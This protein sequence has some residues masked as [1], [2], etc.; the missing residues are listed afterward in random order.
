[1]TPAEKKAFDAGR[2]DLAAA[3]L[4][5]IDKLMERN[6]EQPAGLTKS[7]TLG[8]LEEMVDLVLD[9]IN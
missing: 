4:E 7:I 5:A 9:N 3:I 6:Q 8:V 1:M 2:Q